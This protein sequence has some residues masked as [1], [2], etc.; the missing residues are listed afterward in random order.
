MRDLIV[1]Q[2][3]IVDGVVEAGDWFDAAAVGRTCWTC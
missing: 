3:I 1:T 2:N